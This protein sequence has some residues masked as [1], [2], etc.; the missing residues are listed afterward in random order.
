MVLSGLDV[1]TDFL[2]LNLKAVKHLVDTVI[3]I[4]GLR[5]M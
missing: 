1:F 2:S 3:V 4:A 5:L